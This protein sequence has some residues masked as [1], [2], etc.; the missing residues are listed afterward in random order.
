[1]KGKEWGIKGRRGLGEDL[2]GRK[3]ERGKGNIS[4]ERCNQKNH[5]NSRFLRKN[6]VN[7]ENHFV[8]K[9]SVRLNTA[10]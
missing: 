3:K 2:K 1:L 9:N 4:R 10:E 7:A 6:W 5:W 8:T